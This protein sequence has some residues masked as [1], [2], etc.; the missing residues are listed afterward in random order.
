MPA[1][2]RAVLT[3]PRSDRAT[4]S[5]PIPE[6]VRGAWC[7]LSVP[8]LP[9]TQATAVVARIDIVLTHGG[10]IPVAAAVLGARASKFMIFLPID[11]DTVRVELF[12]D[13]APPAEIV[14]DCVVVSRGAAALHTALRHVPRLFST[15]LRCLR[16]NPRGLLGRLRGEL[17]YLSQTGLHVPYPVWCDLFDR[18]DR[19]ERSPDWPSIDCLVLR[20]DP[21][22]RSAAATYD[23]VASS[24]CIAP[25]AILTA[26][27]EFPATL[28]RSGVAYIGVLQAGEVLAPHALA[29]L[30]ATA[31]HLGH[32]AIL[33]A[34]DDSVTTGGDRFA[35]RFKPPPNHTAMLAGDLCSGIWLIRKDAMAGLTPGSENWA[36]TLRL[37]AW[38]RLYE[39]GMAAE[40]HRVP[41][42]LTHRRADFEPAP[43]SAMAKIVSD[44][45]DRTKLPA[46]VS[47]GR[48][49]RVRFRAPRNAQPR[50]SIVIPSACRSPHV[51]RYISAT[52]A[53]TDYD[54]FEIVIAVS[55]QAPL[56]AAQSAV[57]AALTR[58]PRVRHVPIHAPAFNYAAVNNIAIQTT[59]SPLICLLND[60]IAPLTAD[61]LAIMVG[62]LADPSVGI[63]GARLSYEDRSI[64]HAGVVVLPDGTGEHLHRFTPDREID[65]ATESL[66]SREVSCVTGACLLTRRTLWDR[67][68]G[69]NE[70]YS[71][72][73]NDV[74]FCLRTRELGQ[75]VVFA[76]EAHLLHAESITFGK[77]YGERELDR[78]MADRLRLRSQFPG[79]FESDPFHSPNLSLVRGGCLGLA[80]PPRTEQFDHIGP[81]SA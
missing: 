25:A 51:L 18:W 43:P 14:V 28:A 21:N 32:P 29:V 26:D 66:L 70:T 81:N 41:F 9:R 19:L 53:T 45:I 67:L 36:E 65:T 35:P 15:A 31:V 4:Y 57:I 20:A 10:S 68:G 44:H 11:S 69:M 23:G 16:W 1:R 77:H 30:A 60:D 34:D 24:L 5:G 37:N 56:D 78:N 13:I 6:I 63:V 79:I 38:L 33:Y 49:L 76:A 50:V 59:D 40:T 8:A 46:E 3:L 17:G 58:D 71:S 22:S 55:S 52:L 54:D 2:P 75:G 74:D 48:P 12:G 39:Q 62:H 61:W 27:D 72:A 47:V 42:V 80:V 7:K 64:Q 73:F